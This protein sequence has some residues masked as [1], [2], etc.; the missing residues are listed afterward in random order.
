MLK[1]IKGIFQDGIITP[2][3]RI[4]IKRADV[5]ITFLDSDVEE[6]KNNFLSAAGTWDDLDTEK[7]KNELYKSRESDLRG[8]VQL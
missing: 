8:N 3:E 4:N 5:I 1:T 2:L 6:V 7:L